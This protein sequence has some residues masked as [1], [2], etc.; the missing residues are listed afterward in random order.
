MYECQARRGRSDF[1]F[2]LSPRFPQGPCGSP[3]SPLSQ[4]RRQ[5]CHPKSIFTVS[6]SQLLVQLILVYSL[7][8]IFLDHLIKIVHLFSGIYL[9][10]A[11]SLHAMRLAMLITPTTDGS[12]SL[13]SNLSG[14]YLL[15]NGHGSGHSLCISWHVSWP[16]CP[17]CVNWWHTAS[18]SSLT[19]MSV[20]AWEYFSFSINQANLAP[21]P[22]YVLS[23]LCRGSPWL[24]PRSFSHFVRK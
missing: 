7:L 5:P 23:F 8:S 18:M 22:G 3:F 15:E 16:L 21:R 6:H 2:A 1:F 13:P 4:T 19:A 10:A 24:S 17:L 14:R 9:F 11:I 20:V 12:I